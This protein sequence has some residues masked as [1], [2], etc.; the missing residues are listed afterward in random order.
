M[1]LKVISLEPPCINIVHFKLKIYRMGYLSN[2]HYPRENSSSSSSRYL[3]D[4]ID[5]MCR[6]NGGNRIRSTLA[7]YS[8]CTPEKK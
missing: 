1:L 4:P 5:K 6:N 2:I 8:E 3:A 7:I